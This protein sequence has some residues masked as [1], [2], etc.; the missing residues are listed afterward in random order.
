MNLEIIKSLLR[1]DRKYYLAWDPQSYVYLKISDNLE[2]MV[3]HSYVHTMEGYIEYLAK[4]N[5]PPKGLELD[6]TAEQ[7]LQHIENDLSFFKSEDDEELFWEYLE[8]SIVHLQAAIIDEELEKKWMEAD[9]KKYNFAK[10][11]H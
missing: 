10:D 5:H 3:K 9:I 4:Y 2:D 1:D 7:L 11:S 8:D 6:L